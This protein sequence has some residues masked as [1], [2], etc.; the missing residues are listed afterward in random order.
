MFFKQV[1]I[2][3]KIVKYIV[4]NNKNAKSYFSCKTAAILVIIQTTL[5]T[6]PVKRGVFHGDFN[7]GGYDSFG[8][9]DSPVFIK[10]VIFNKPYSPSPAEIA[11]A[12]QAAKEAASNVMAAQHRVQDAKDDVLHQQHLAN[13]KQAQ[14]A[15]AL[16]KAEAAA[17]VQ[18]Q[19]AKSAANS[20]I[21][22]QQRL[23]H[24]KA[25]VAELQRIAA[26]K[27]GHAASLIHKSANAAA[28]E[29]Q[30]TGIKCSTYGRKCYF[31]PSES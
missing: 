1:N 20:L 31:T 12:I 25:E 28:V 8:P 10:P 15:L 5:S 7:F 9:L 18:Q 26:A 23:A 6:N 30:K 17:A 21:Q 11:S 2:Q 4:N 14:A 13:H 22:A 29:V 24:A 19:E 27:E 16:Q 3:L